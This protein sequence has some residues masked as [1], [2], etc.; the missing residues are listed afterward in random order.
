MGD[1]RILMAVTEL[2]NRKKIDALVD[3]LSRMD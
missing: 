1:D 2:H 3:V